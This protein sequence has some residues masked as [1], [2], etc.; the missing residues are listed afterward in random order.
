M[1]LIN[2]ESDYDSMYKNLLDDLYCTLDKNQNLRMGNNIKIAKPDVIFDITRKTVWRNFSTNCNQ[3]K[4]SHTDVQNFIE[5][6]YSTTTSINAGGQLLIKGR[7]DLN[8]IGGTLKKYIKNYVQCSI[9]LSA[10]TSIER[11]INMR[12]D[13]LKCSMCNAERVISNK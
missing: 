10:Q 2:I 8:I 5:K 1:E 12:L 13:Y 11:N 7:Y 4:R 6:E 3:I 9:C